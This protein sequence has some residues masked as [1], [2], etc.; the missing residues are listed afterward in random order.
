MPRRGAERPVLSARA[1][2]ID[3]AS[4]TTIA[5]T[6]RAARTFSLLRMATASQDQTARR[7][8]LAHHL[9]S[10]SRSFARALLR[11]SSL[12]R[13]ATTDRPNLRGVAAAQGTATLAHPN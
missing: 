9:T 4:A 6:Q 12:L 10:F 13:F 5:A 2:T 8:V 1:A 7:G 11:R 3:A